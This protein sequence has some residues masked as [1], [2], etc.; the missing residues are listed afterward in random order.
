MWWSVIVDQD[1]KNTSVIICTQL[2]FDVPDEILFVRL[3][4]IFYS[5]YTQV[6]IYLI[7]LMTSKLGLTDNLNIQDI[8][9]S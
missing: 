7:C 9:L 2:A 6:F 4:L 8:V 3:I 1:D 5:V